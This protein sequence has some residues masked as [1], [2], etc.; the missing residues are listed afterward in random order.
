MNIDNILV[1]HPKDETTDFLSVIYRDINATVIRNPVSKS[2]LKDLM[3]SADRII[4][5]GHGTP[6]GLGYLRNHELYSLV[7]STLVYLLREKNDNIYIWCHA[8]EFV[9]KYDLKG[10][11]T[12]MFI[13]EVAE[14]EFFRVVATGEEISISNNKFAKILSENVLKNGTEILDVLK[15]DYYSADSSVISYNNN[16]LYNFRIQEIL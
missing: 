14:A 5:L 8:D 3:K 4:M 11:S 15:K 2:K 10:F 7:D 12:G 9:K 1:I 16:R 13:S 6:S